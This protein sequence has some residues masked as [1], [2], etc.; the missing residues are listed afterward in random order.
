MPVFHSP[1]DYFDAAKSPD[2]SADELREL[3]QCDYPFVLVAIASH[4]NATPDALE[5][6]APTTVIADY[7]QELARALG[8]N[9][10][11]PPQVLERLADGLFPFLSGGRGGQ[12]AIV[13]AVAVCLNPHTPI[14]PIRRILCSDNTHLQVR[15]AVAR[16][17][18]RD[19]VLECLAHDRSE[20]VRRHV[21]RQRQS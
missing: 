1:K 9:P 3:A 15:K 7:D 2:A 20:K 19:A 6:A 13:A 18:T 21:A 5:A 16:E 10:M 12:C 8:V 14:E 4:P 11:T 17:T